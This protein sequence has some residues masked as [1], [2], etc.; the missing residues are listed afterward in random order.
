[1]SG[2]KIGGTVCL[3]LAAASV[4]GF[5]KNLKHT[6][7]FSPDPHVQTSYMIGQLMVPLVLAI[8]G[9]VLLTGRKKSA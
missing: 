2:K 7:S 3:V 6:A 8:V 9:L 1:M 4:L 5:V